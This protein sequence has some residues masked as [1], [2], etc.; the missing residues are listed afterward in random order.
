MQAGDIPSFP[1][2]LNFHMLGEVG[3]FSIHTLRWLEAVFY[4]QVDSWQYLD[5]LRLL[6]QLPN[7]SGPE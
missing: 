5:I 3:R 1:L 4:Y 7:H 2:R 6:V